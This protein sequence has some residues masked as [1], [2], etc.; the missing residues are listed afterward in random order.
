MVTIGTSAWS[1]PSIYSTMDYQESQVL[2]A[3]VIDW[4]FTS[5]DGD[6]NTRLFIDDRYISYCWS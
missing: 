4:T 6:F 3:V 1:I 2:V 5:G